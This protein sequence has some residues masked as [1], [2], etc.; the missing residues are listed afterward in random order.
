MVLD[1]IVDCIEA[2]QGYERSTCRMVGIR[3]VH[4]LKVHEVPQLVAGLSPSILLPYV[5]VLSCVDRGFVVLLGWNKT[6]AG[7]NTARRSR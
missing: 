3:Q 6:G 1:R 7:L 5:P 2:R 4:W